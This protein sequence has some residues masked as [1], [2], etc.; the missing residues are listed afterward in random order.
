[1]FGRKNL[2]IS[3]EIDVSNMPVLKGAAEFLRMWSIVD[4]PQV[5]LIDPTVLGPDPFCFGLTL[6]DCVQHAAKAYSQACDITEN[7]AF[8]RILEGFDA[9]RSNPTD[10]ALQ[11]SGKPN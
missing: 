8:S 10:V 2:P 9:E 6:M 1:M 7:H 5:C 11:T 4:G 3:G